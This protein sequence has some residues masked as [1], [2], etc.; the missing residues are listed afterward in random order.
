MVVWK[1]G[2][3]LCFLL[4]LSLTHLP[5]LALLCFFYRHPL[6]TVKTR[7]Q[8]GGDGLLTVIGNTAKKEGIGGFYKGIVWA[9][10]REGSYLFIFRYIL[11]T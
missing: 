6:E 11:A 10:G 2:V 8:V 5:A 7:M 9:W 3:V 1:N 4:F